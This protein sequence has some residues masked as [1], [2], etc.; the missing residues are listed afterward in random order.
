MDSCIIP[1]CSVNILDI[2]DILNQHWKPFFQANELIPKFL[3]DRQL[4]R[5]FVVLIVLI[6]EC[7]VPVNKINQ[8]LGLRNFAGHYG[9]LS[10]LDDLGYFLSLGSLDNQNVS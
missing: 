5:L 6:L 2:L 8:G 4:W 10:C 3:Y 1:K 7:F 9:L